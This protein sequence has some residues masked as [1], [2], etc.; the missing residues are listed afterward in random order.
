M[1]VELSQELLEGIRQGDSAACRSVYDRYKGRIYTLAFRICQNEADAMDVLQDSLVQAFSRIDQFRGQHFWPWLRRIA[2]NQ[3]LSRLRRLRR[4]PVLAVAD[5]E[6]L[7]PAD[8][9]GLNLDLNAAFGRL[10]PRT[11]AVVWLYDVEGYSHEEIASLF[12]RSVS[13]SKTRLSRA[14]ES[15]RH[16]LSGEES[17]SCPAQPCQA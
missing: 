14:H 15:M 2:V 10:P 11:R 9:A 17:Q 3:C 5:E 16:W 8:Q 7:A 4:Q 13:F 1:T 6:L 12:G